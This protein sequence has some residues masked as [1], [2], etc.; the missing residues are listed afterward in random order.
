MSA[1]VV[2]VSIA[3]LA[4]GSLAACSTM[5]EWTKPTTWYDGATAPAEAKTTEA[6]KPEAPK[7]VD[8]A[9]TKVS[10]STNPV[11]D[12]LEPEP[13]KPRITASEAPA[14]FPNLASQPAA[15]EATTSSA[16]RREIRDSLAADR[17]N[18][19]YTADELRGGSQPAAAPPAPADKAAAK[20]AKPAETK[21]EDKPAEEKASE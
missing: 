20:P 5:P 7:T 10:N 15:R 13:V 14:E 16:Q 11:I 4:A 19:Q 6:A 1:L 18:A 8:P 9:A 3:V 21:A 2:R 17:D 12:P